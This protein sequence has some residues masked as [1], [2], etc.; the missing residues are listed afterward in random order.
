V[1]AVCLVRCF[2]FGVYGVFCCVGFV[3]W[4]GFRAWL[5][6]EAFG[7]FRVFEAGVGLK[8]SRHGLARI[9]AVAHS[10]LGRRLR[11]FQRSDCAAR[12]ASVAS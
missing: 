3:S 5:M 2:C 8:N 4:L 9:V 1:R 12:C 11:M 10:F 7:N 6:G